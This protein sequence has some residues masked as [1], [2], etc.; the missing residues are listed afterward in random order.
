MTNTKSVCEESNSTEQRR[1]VGLD[2][3]T[4][5]ITHYSANAST[6]TNVQIQIRKYNHANTITQIQIQTQIQIRSDDGDPPIVSEIK[7]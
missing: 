7:F 3:N 2:R 1:D 4:Q 6:N 5:A